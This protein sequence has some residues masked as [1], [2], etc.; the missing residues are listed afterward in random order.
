MKREWK[1]PF[2]QL[3]PTSFF[4]NAETKPNYTIHLSVSTPLSYCSRIQTQ[5]YKLPNWREFAGEFSQPNAKIVDFFTTHM[6]IRSLGELET[7]KKT[8]KIR[9]RP[10]QKTDANYVSASAVRVR[11]WDLR[12]L[13]YCCP[14]QY[15]LKI[16][17]NSDLHQ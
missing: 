7:R 17:P 15:N 14:A 3:F 10:E 12:F 4:K 9:S 2:L 11:A 5:I 8:R 6:L 1:I 16:R 13:Q